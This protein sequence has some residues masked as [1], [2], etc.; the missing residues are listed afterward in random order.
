MNRRSNT[1]KT[2]TKGRIPIN[3]RLIKQRSF[4]L[5]LEIVFTYTAKGTNPVIGNIFERRSGHDATFRI[6]HCRVIHPATYYANILF[7]HH[8]DFNCFNYFLYYRYFYFK[9]PIGFKQEER[10]NSRMLISFF[11]QFTVLSQHQSP[12]SLGCSL[13]GQDI[14]IHL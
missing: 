13:Q 2:H 4:L 3:K 12:F 14:R 1:P 9:F 11:L 7:H 5:N 10:T 6:S 8:K